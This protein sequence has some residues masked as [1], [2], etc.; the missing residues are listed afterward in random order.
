MNILVTGDKGFVAKNLI[1]QLKKKRHR[2]IILEKK[3]NKKVEI[4]LKNKKIDVLIHCAGIAHTKVSKNT[5]YFNN[6]NVT[7]ILIESI[8][9]SYLKKIIFLSTSKINQIKYY[10]NKKLLK[11]Y[12]DY[13]CESKI[14]AENFIKDYCQINNIKYSI[15]RPTLIY[16]KGVKGN[17]YRLAKIIKR[18]YPLPLKAF[19]TNKSYLSIKN[20][21]TFILKLLTDKKT[22]NQTFLI[23]DNEPISLN[24]LI[25]KLYN[26]NNFKN[27]NFYLP[28]FLINFLLYLMGKR[29]LIISL[30][31]D[32]IVQNNELIKK[33]KWTPKN[34]SN[35]DLK[36][37]YYE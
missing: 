15:I 11:N 10:K 3:I 32:F 5:I 16:G 9:K 27:R 12:K 4:S 1:P 23:S 21:S 17:L 31:N 25:S 37:I 29:E 13:Y 33:I 36:N 19:D 6:Y 8:D 2:I 14:K 7:K 34:F 26:I 18:G 30:N 20:L 35:Q 28:K 24:I 22:N